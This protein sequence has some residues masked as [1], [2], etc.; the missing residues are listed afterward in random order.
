MGNN[1][2]N[3]QRT[4]PRF[5][6]PPNGSLY[7]GTSAVNNFESNNNATPCNNRKRSSSNVVFNSVEEQ[8]LNSAVL[9][10]NTIQLYLQKLDLLYQNLE[11]RVQ[12]LE[13]IVADQFVI[14][15]TNNSFANSQIN[16]PNSGYNMSDFSV[17]SSSSTSTNTLVHAAVQLSNNLVPG[18]S[19]S[20]ICSLLET[21]SQREI[22]VT[23]FF[24]FY[25]KYFLFRN[26]IWMIIVC[27]YFKREQHLQS[28]N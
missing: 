9:D 19:T 28:G 7:F 11:G 20:T 1:S 13:N 4:S 25:L 8:N 3:P 12:K 21:S 18:G 2:N 15:S 22:S 27:L 10:P 16:N 14:A 24:L 6:N 26:L 17:G 23:S 5:S